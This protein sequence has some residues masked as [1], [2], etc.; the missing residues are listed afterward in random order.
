M[1]VRLLRA[2]AMLVLL[3][4]VPLFLSAGTLRWP[5]AWGWI[6]LQV[7]GSLGLW[8][9]LW[10]HDPALLAER[11]RGVTQPGQ[12]GWDRTLMRVL[13]TVFLVWLVLMGLDAERF[14]WSVVPPVVKAVGAAL[15]VLSY[16]VMFTTFRANTFLAPVVR[17]QSE[18]GHRVISTGP[19]GVV[20]HPMYAGAL[21][22]F[23][24]AP[25]QVGSWWGLCGSAVIIALMAMRTVREEALLRQDLHG[26]EAYMRQVRYRL[27]PGVW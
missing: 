18:R 21:A 13:M 22:L 23:I 26:Y 5:E 4:G 15:G 14:G 27:I 8:M 16:A 17:V 9:F 20:R 19:Y 24:G 12:A 11:E 25:L 6:A 7:A 3:F 2:M 10:R 1:L